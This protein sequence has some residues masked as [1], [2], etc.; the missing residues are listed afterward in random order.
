[1]RFFL[2]FVVM[3]FCAAAPALAQDGVENAPQKFEGLDKFGINAQKQ[4]EMIDHPVVRLQSLDKISARTET[5]EMR[6][7][8]TV[9]FGSLFIKAQACR[10][11]PP[12]EEP[13]SAAFL[14][15]WE[16]EKDHDSPNLGESKWVFSGWMFASSPALSPMDHP[17]FDVWVLD[18][19]DAQAAPSVIETDAA[20]TSE[21]GAADPSA[22]E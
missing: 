14:Q 4:R 9:R 10:K 12:I 3:L 13:E 15:V 16:V 5:F 1:M 19:L 8:S 2:T 22:S 21:D 20:E 11:A 18:C 7:G 17:V 6:V